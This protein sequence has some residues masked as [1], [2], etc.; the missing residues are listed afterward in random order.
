MGAPP[1]ISAVWFPLSQRT[2]STAIITQSMNLGTLVGFGTS[3]FLT[4]SS[5]VY[6]LLRGEAVVSIAIF[7]MVIVYFPAKP[8]PPPIPSLGGGTN[9]SGPTIQQDDVVPIIPSGGHGSAEGD[10]LLSSPHFNASAE[11]KQKLVRFW[12]DILH[13][14]KIPAFDVVAMAYGVTSGVVAGWQAVLVPLLEPLGYTQVQVG[15]MG[16]CGAIGAMLVAPIAGRISDWCHRKVKPVYL[17]LYAGFTVSMLL[18][19]LIVSGVIPNWLPAMYMLSICIIA[20]INVVTPVVYELAVDI[21]FP[22]TEST[23]C[24]ILVLLNNVACLVFLLVGDMQSVQESPAW[25]NWAVTATGAV[26]F[27]AMLFLKWHYPRQVVD[28]HN[29]STQQP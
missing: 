10:P 5:Q 9:I 6:P 14:I 8:P 3:I 26:V 22:V 11:R 18:F 15:R 19:C 24:G 17:S 4:E 21:T 7:L 13:I 27:V 20:T 16:C 25:L 23:S 1:L 12:K 2:L 28:D 29:K